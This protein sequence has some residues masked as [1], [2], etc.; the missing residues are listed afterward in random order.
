MPAFKPPTSWKIFEEREP[1][2]DFLIRR[3]AANIRLDLGDLNGEIQ[4]ITHQQQV[5]GRPLTFSFTGENLKNV[6]SAEIEGVLDHVAPDRS[7]D[8]V[9]A[10]IRGYALKDVVISEK[11][12]MPLTLAE[13]LTDLDL[14]TVLKGEN[15]AATIDAA[16]TSTR[17]SSGSA[18]K[19]A[20]ALNQAI[21]SALA[22]IS[23]FQVNADI[24]G[25]LDSYDIHL[26]SDMDAVLKDAV[27]Q[28]VK[29]ETAK[30]EK[31]L[32]Q[33]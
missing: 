24:K 25:T 9:A 7:E 13:A 15:I 19:Q 21:Q 10:K 28:V 27:G 17:L 23:S 2:P 11:E 8:R 26:K 1:L 33:A 32:K 6:T 20:G 22:G 18:T 4:D 31:Q 14:K 3:A 16:L 12:T 29:T 5:L 30:F